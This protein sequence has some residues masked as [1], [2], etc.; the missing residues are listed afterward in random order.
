MLEFVRNALLRQRSGKV[1]SMS[2]AT[3]A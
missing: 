2:S 3:S 1:A